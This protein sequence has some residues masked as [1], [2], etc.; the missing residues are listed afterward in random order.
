MPTQPDKLARK[1]GNVIQKRRIELG[2]SQEVLGERSNLARTYISD[3]ERGA[4]NMSVRT[5]QQLANAL[6]MPGWQLFFMAEESRRSS[7]R[8]KSWSL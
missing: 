8:S 5:L 1:F 2:L 4:R 6:N 7:S 3:V